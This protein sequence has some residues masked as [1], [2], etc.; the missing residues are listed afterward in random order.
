MSYGGPDRRRGGPDRRAVGERIRILIVDDH[1]LVRVGMRAILE[2][3]PDFEIVGEAEDGRAAHDVA[4]ET[5][6][7]IILMDLSLPAPG[8]SAWR[9]TRTRR[10]SS[11]RSAPAPPRSSSRTS[12]RTTS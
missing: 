9:P 4:L 6:P 2:R 1:A 3:E 10:R 12:A 7:A 8:S 5:D 11:R